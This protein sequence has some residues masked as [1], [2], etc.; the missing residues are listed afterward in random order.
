[1]QMKH[2]EGMEQ[3]SMVQERLEKLKEYL[4]SFQDDKLI[5]VLVCHSEVIWWLTSDVKNGKR[6]GI[7]TENG[8]LVD[9]TQ[10]IASGSSHTVL[11]Y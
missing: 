5:I 2:A 9:I 4:R 10:V 3:D 8:E 6:D 1:M 11:L 7:W